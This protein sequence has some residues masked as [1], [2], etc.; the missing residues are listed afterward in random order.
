MKWWDR[1]LKGQVYQWK[2][3]IRTSKRTILFNAYVTD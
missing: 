2:G 3:V 1:T